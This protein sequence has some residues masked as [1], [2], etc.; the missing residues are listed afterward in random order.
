MAPPL[1]AFQTDEHQP[2]LWPGGRQA[3]LLVHGFPGT[4]AE[5]RTAGEVIHAGGWTVQGLLLPGFG[6][7]FQTLPARRHIDWI[8]AID[9][10]VAVLR[11]EHDTVL[12]VGNSMGAALALRVAAHH[13]VDGLILFAPFWRVDSWLDKVYP[14]AERVLPQV[15]P[16]RRADFADVRFRAGVLQFI[17]EADLDDP[18]VQAA[19]RELRLP[20]HVLGQVRRSGQLGYRFAAQVHAPV[21]IIQ[22]SADPLVKPR[23]TKRLAAR[24]PNLAGYVEVPGEHELIRGKSAA[25]PLVTAAMRAFLG[26]FGENLGMDELA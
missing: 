9:H 8:E 3:A 12:L 10:A 7:D 25:W 19:I 13:A 14:L 18:T 15:K 1:Q 24:L 20:V 17:P 22:G 6:V 26:R 23:V 11:Q 16:F 4:P 2:F 5:M 21:L